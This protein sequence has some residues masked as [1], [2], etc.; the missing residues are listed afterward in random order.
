MSRFPNARSVE[1]ILKT[2]LERQGRAKAFVSVQQMPGKS[3]PLYIITTES[4]LALLLQSFLEE[5]IG[6]GCPY[7]QGSFV[8]QGADV[9]RLLA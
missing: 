2:H 7:T 1:L 5:R 6:R 4:S 8:L 9:K 3:D